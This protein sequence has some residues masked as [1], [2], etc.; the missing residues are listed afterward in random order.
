MIHQPIQTRADGDALRAGNGRL[1]VVF[2]RNR[3]TLAFADDLVLRCA[4]A[5]AGLAAPIG[6]VSVAVDDPELL[7]VVE[8]GLLVPE[9]TFRVTYELF[10]TGN[11]HVYVRLAARAE[12]ELEKVEL[13]RITFERHRLSGLRDEVRGT[14]ERWVDLSGEELSLGVVVKKMPWQAKWND[15]GAYGHAARSDT[16][17]VMSTDEPAVSLRVRGGVRLAVGETLEAGLFLRPH[18]GEHE[19]VVAEATHRHADELRYLPEGEYLHGQLWETETVWLGPPIFEGCPQRPYDQL[20]PRPLGLDVLARK[21]FTW[22]NE[23]FSLWRVTGKDRYWESGIKKAYA[24]MD[25]QNE[26]GG[27][28]EGIEF[29]NLPPHHHHM[30]DT[31]IGGLFLLEAYDLTGSQ[32]FLD[33]AARCKQFWLGPPPANSHTTD[34]PGAWWYRWGGYI[35]EFGYTDERHVLNTHAGATEFLAL[36]YERTGDAE[37]GAGMQN[38]IAGFKWGLERGIQKDNG[39]FLYCLSQ[40]DPTLERPGDPPYI[41]L[42]LVPQIEDVYTV[43]SSYRL[44]MANRITR[45]DAV[46]SAV[47]RALDYW[48]LGY[49]A[50]AVYTYRAYA[51]I[52]YALAAGEIDIRYA[53]ALP[54]LLKDPNHFTSMQR[55]LSSFIAPAGLPGLRVDVVAAGPSFVEPVFLRRSNCEFMFALVNVEYPQ[56]GLE[57]TVELP[58]GARVRSASQVDPAS[59]SQSSLQF[60]VRRDEGHVAIRVGDIGEFGVTVVKLELEE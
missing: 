15:V 29:Y 5:C 11:L 58:D 39:Q 36:Y 1:E 28:W 57:V 56:R 50:G 51:V 3:G 4:P 59:A 27:W 46:T 33:A 26:Y 17:I 23:D 20:I 32:R 10:Q 14:G 43:A 19:R 60:D 35:N 38:G 54:M 12:V 34:A 7:R 55:G 42:D 52:A 2:D 40:V 53:L 21:R 48:W 8:Q 24:L 37:A 13:P 45:D 41:Q 44:M 22:N 16:E 25:T 6:E 47:R 30:Y 9:V 31:Y 18:R 49:Q